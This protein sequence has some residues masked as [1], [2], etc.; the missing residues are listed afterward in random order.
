MAT[1]W[2]CS[3][4]AGREPGEI[5]VQAGLLAL[6]G[7]VLHR[8]LG[9]VTHQ[10]HVVLPPGHR[11]LVDP[12]PRRHVGPAAGPAPGHGP[13][14]DLPGLIPADPQDPRGPAHVRLPQ[15]VDGQA[16]EQRGEPRPGLGPGQAHLPHA[17][18][19]TLHPRRPGVQVGLELATIQ[20]APRPLLPVVVQGQ[21]GRTLRA[22]PARAVGMAGPDLDPLLLHLQL[23]PEDRPRRG[24]PQQLPIEFDVLHGGVR[25]LP[26]GCRPAMLCPRGLRC[27]PA[28]QG[29]SSD[30]PPAWAG[31]AGP[32][33]R[34]DGPSAPG[35]P[36]DPCGHQKADAHMRPPA[37]RRIP[38]LQMR[39]S[40]FHPPSPSGRGLSSAEASPRGR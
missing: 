34:S 12:Q 25:A 15:H 27:A 6:V 30:A 32:G 22:R 21:R 7:Q 13:A 1:A 33:H 10:R 17:M 11:R 28:R 8:P 37:R 38:N 3:R 29:G 31:V 35:K 14:F 2:I 18:G 39:R 24:Q 9:Q 23:H 19:G 26:S 4:C 16:L 20:M 40:D 5:A 36:V